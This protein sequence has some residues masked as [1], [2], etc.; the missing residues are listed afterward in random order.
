M[1]ETRSP[2]EAS[3]LWTIDARRRTEGGFLGSKIIID[4]IEKGTKQKRVGFVVLSG[5]P[6]R[7]KSPIFNY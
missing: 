6:A 1:D 3:L 5:P 4:Q 7:R 2:I